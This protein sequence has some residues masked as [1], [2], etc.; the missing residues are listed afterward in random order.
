MLRPLWAE[1]STSKYK[2]KVSRMR[3]SRTHKKMNVAMRQFIRYELIMAILNSGWLQKNWPAI[4]S[5]IC[6]FLYLTSIH[7]VSIKCWHCFSTKVLMLYENCYQGISYKWK[8][9]INPMIFILKIF[10]FIQINVDPSLLDVNK[11]HS[12]QVIYPYYCVPSWL[13]N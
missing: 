12:I 4:L 6:L 9:Q 1:A 10:I 8:Q 11:E 7:W 2:F 5:F 13:K 3:S